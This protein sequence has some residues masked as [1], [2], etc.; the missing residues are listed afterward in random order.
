M[1]ASCEPPSA[2][3]CGAG[4]GR[5]GLEPFVVVVGGGGDVVAVEPGG[6]RG[7]FFGGALKISL[8]RSVLT[9]VYNK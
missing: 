1:S 8:A 4:Q 2:E 7:A 5:G 3:G 9:H 6:G